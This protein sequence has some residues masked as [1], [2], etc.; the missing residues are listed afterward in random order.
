MSGY[1]F[2]RKT[3]THSFKLEH[4]NVVAMASNLN[5]L[6]FQKRAVHRVPFL[7]K[8]NG[9]GW[10][11]NLTIRAMPDN[12]VRDPFSLGWKKCN[13]GEN[14]AVL[15]KKDLFKK[16]EVELVKTELLDVIHKQGIADLTKLFGKVFDNKGRRVIEMA[17]KPGFKYTYAGKTVPGIAFTAQVRELVIPKMTEIFGLDVKDLWAHLV[18]YPTSECKLDW[19]DDGEGFNPH[20]IVSITFLEKP[21]TGARAFQVRLKSSFPNGFKGRSSNTSASKKRKIK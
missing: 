13:I 7:A 4:G 15:I 19:R 9:E 21:K 10:R 8:N 6:G 14:C 17:D 18:Y 20:M 5:T 11:L 3:K 12:Q 2:D 1:S 16:S